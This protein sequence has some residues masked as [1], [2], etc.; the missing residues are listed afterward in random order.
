M[1]ETPRNTVR[2]ASRGNGGSAVT[3]RW[4]VIDTLTKAVYAQPN[5]GVAEKVA[6]MH[7]N[8]V[9]VP[10][11]PASMMGQTLVVEAAQPFPFCEHC[12]GPYTQQPELMAEYAG[13]WDTCPNRPAR[14]QAAQLRANF[15]EVE[16]NRM[17][18]RFY[19]T[20]SQSGDIVYMTMTAKPLIVESLRAALECVGKA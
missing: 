15:S 4:S 3:D 17:A 6:E 7:G 19:E 5:K 11:W 20:S 18:Q 9:V 10:G 14:G 13:H 2:G 16:L 12:A 1:D 8:C